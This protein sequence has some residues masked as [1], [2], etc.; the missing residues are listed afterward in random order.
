MSRSRPILLFAFSLL[1]PA[2]NAAAA[3]SAPAY[4]QVHAVF[5]KHCV[6][7]HNAK[8]EE[9]ELVL[10]SYATLMKGGET[11]PAVV[12]GKADESLLIRLIRHEKKPY[13]PPPKKAPKLSDA[14]I[15]VVKAWVD[16]GAKPGDVGP[17][18][19]APAALP[20]VEPRVAPRKAVN[21]V[22]FAAGP[23]LYA[24]A[25]YGEVELRSAAD[26][27]LVR[28]LTGHKGNVNA[29]VFSADGSRL[30]A[31]AGYPGVVGDVRV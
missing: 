2:F 17:V 27:S 20:K 10:E 3:E 18:A 31:A 22:A 25:R 15:A 5:A 4:V 9:G 8:D 12:P 23:K 16:A 21:A 19:A 11:G 28:R 30:I 7:C 24:V 14:E 6:S 1:I 26:R 13:M 29:V